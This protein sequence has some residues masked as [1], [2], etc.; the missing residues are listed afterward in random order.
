MTMQIKGKQIAGLPAIAIRNMLRSAHSEFGQDYVA[1]TCNLSD[2]RAKQ[3]VQRLMDDGYVEFSN[4]VL[5]N[6]N[7]TGGRKRRY[8]D[9]N[10][11][12]LTTKGYKLAQASAVNKMPRA[13]AEVIISCFLKRVEEVNANESYLCCISTVIVYGSYAR[14]ETLLSDVDVAVNLREKWS[15]DERSS[16]S[17]ER[18]RLARNNGRSFGTFIDELDWPRKE[19]MLHLKARTKGLSIHLMDDFLGMKKDLYFQYKVL[20]GDGEKVAEQLASGAMG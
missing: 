11:F 4:R 15:G 14:E 18:V 12:Q 7:P 5:A 19:V 2:R 6:L 10:Y 3:L 16:R 9:K 1:T 17:E 13:R 8:G 20:L